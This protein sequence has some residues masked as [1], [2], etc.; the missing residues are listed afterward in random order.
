M[1]VSSSSNIGLIRDEHYWKSNKIS[2]ELI[3]LS[4]KTFTRI[5]LVFG[6]KYSG[7]ANSL[8]LTI[9]RKMADVYFSRMHCR[10][11]K[12]ENGHLLMDRH[13]AGWLIC[14]LC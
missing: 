10:S 9:T 3:E 5:K 4:M 7:R 13:K 6:I 11:F 12:K 8:E 2:L 1:Y 14:S